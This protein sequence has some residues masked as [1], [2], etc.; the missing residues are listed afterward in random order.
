MLMLAFTEWPSCCW[1]VLGKEKPS[2][3][4][5]SSQ[6]FAHLQR[7]GWRPLQPSTWSILLPWCAVCPNA[8]QY[9]HFVF[10][11]FCP[12]ETLLF[13]WLLQCESTLSSERVFFSHGFEIKQ[14]LQESWGIWHA[15]P[16]VVQQN[17]LERWSLP[18]LSLRV[19]SN[20]RNSGTL[21]R[22]ILTAE[23]PA[24]C[25]PWWA[26]V[27]RWI[28]WVSSPSSWSGAGTGL[29]LGEGPAEV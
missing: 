1:T 26:E 23:P 20:C 15:F 13:S 5:K 24:G 8:G 18:S 3:A 7:C 14:E 28:S 12:R 27:H 22:L 21:L 9:N 19:W 25:Q 29:Q 11:S 16:F 4:W 10:W 6:V 2:L 17:S